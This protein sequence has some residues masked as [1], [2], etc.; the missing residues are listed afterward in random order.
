[1]QSLKGSLTECQNTDKTL[2][3]YK[4]YN[5]NY[6]LSLFESIRLLN[7]DEC[8]NF[9]DFFE[10]V[11]TFEEIYNNLTFHGD[12]EDNIKYSFNPVITYLYSLNY[13]V[14][15]KLIEK[16]QSCLDITRILITS[17]KINRAYTNKDFGT[18]AT[19]CSSM[20]Q[21]LFIEIIENSESVTKVKPNYSDLQK[22]AIDILNI[23]KK[24]VKNDDLKKFIGSFNN[25]LASVNT[26]RNAYSDSHGNSAEKDNS[27]SNLP[28]H[29]YK[30]LIDTTFSLVN[31]I[32]GSQK[33]Q[34]EIKNNN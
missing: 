18:V 6:I 26:M 9:L 3:D 25:A 28:S 1:M 15:I 2:S 31:F 23:S 21:S 24:Q 20:I 22:Q 16:Q 5:S 33:Y 19:N 32:V 17:E 12:F 11:C 10:N 13:T 27:F 7:S 30:F 14:E 29:H 8:N 34:E 4:Q